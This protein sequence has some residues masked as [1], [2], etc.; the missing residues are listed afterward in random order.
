MKKRFVFCDSLT[1][2]ERRRVEALNLAIAMMP[3]AC[4]LAAYTREAEQIEAWIIE[5]NPGAFDAVPFHPNVE[6]DERDQRR[7]EAM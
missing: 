2:A 1:R 5:A 3:D 7:F 4:D 6:P